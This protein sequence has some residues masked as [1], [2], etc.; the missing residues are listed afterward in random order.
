[1]ATYLQGD[2]Y[3]QRP[4]RLLIVPRPDEIPNPF[5]S[6]AAHMKS[7]L[8][9]EL[10]GEVNKC[11]KNLLGYFQRMDGGNEGNVDFKMM[12]DGMDVADGSHGSSARKESF[13]YVVN[14]FVAAK[15]LQPAETRSR[16]TTH[17][18]TGRQSSHSREFRFCKDQFDKLSSHFEQ[19]IERRIKEDSERRPPST[20]YRDQLQSYLRSFIPDHPT[21]HFA[22]LPALN[23]TVSDV[24]L[25]KSQY[26]ARVDVCQSIFEIS[27]GFDDPD[28]AFEDVAKMA[29]RFLKLYSVAAFRGS[30]PGLPN[31]TAKAIQGL[32]Q[33]TSPEKTPDTKANDKI[34]LAISSLQAW[35]PKR[36]IVVEYTFEEV[37]GGGYKGTVTLK[38]PEGD[39]RSYSDGKFYAR[40]KEA[41]EAV[42][43]L[44]CGDLKI[45]IQTT[46]WSDRIEQARNELN[47]FL[48]LC[49]ADK[50]QAEFIYTCNSP[51]FACTV[52]LDD[53]RKW[54]SHPEYD[55]PSKKA[56]RM[57]ACCMA[58]MELSGYKLNEQIHPKEWKK[59][60]TKDSGLQ[61]RKADAISSPKNGTE[62]PHRAFEKDKRRKTN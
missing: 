51:P 58:L 55:F 17:S 59:G 42:A 35:V 45:P 21:L 44:A 30:V 33:T 29:Y 46:S 40:K 49:A 5:D 19:V 25:K 14:F 12:W 6:L 9:S 53:G 3:E 23:K 39:V 54:D 11:I 50:R 15:V 24:V 57:S 61:K 8:S 13:P 41:K 4:C 26:R 22:A 56:A 2:M 28:S 48:E 18:D 31:I 10:R 60:S 47:L 20:T 43:L 37:G 32:P 52:K 38:F 16:N 1:M 36:K 27:S 7:L 34:S 62:S